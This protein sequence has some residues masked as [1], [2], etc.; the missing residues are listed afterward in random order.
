MNKLAVFFKTNKDKPQVV[1]HPAIAL[2]LAKA[3]KLTL[4]IFSIVLFLILVFSVSEQVS[5]LGKEN[6]KE[7]HQKLQ[8]VNDKTNFLI[9]GK[10]ITGK[11]ILCSTQHCGLLTGSRALVVPVNDNFQATWPLNNE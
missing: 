11:V 9:N 7:K 2:V 6:A 5:N 8:Q 3:V 4:L 10:K 1:G